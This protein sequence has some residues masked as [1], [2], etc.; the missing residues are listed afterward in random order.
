MVLARLLEIYEVVLLPFGEN[1]R[2][3]LVVDT[4]SDLIRVQCKTGR[5]RN[6]VIKFA[7]CS[8]TYHH[9]NQMD[10]KPYKHDYRGT[11][12]MFGVYCPE[13]DRTYLVPVDEIGKNLGSLRVERTQNNQELKIRWAGQYEIGTPK[14][15][16]LVMKPLVLSGLPSAQESEGPSGSLF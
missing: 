7:A 1:Q 15:G 14:A 16:E 8:V 4:G 5:L 2:Y 10:A 12:D 6:G 13:N 9:P 3:D 11:A